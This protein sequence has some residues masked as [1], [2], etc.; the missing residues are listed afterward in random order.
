ML[1]WTVLSPLCGFLISGL[2]GT[3]LGDRASQLITCAFM[4]L[5]VAMACLTAFEVIHLGHE[6]V[7]P[8]FT[9][10]EVGD[11]QLSWDVRL[12]TLSSVMSLI[13]TV[14]S[15][16]VHVYSIGYMAKDP[17][18]PRFMSYLSL[19]TFMMLMLVTAQNLIQ[20]F[21]G[22]EGV[23]LTSYLLI[24]FW[25]FKDSAKVFYIIIL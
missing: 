14:V 16:C 21:F 4:F 15:F 5:S 20:L 25:Y 2:L 8:L 24:G 3:R 9:F 10:L 1:A 18:I 13:V 6:Q 17:S 7:I 11:L 19:F 22:W 12:D 23:G